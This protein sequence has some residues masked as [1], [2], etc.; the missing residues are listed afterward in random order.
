MNLTVTISNMRHHHVITLTRGNLLIKAGQKKHPA[1]YNSCCQIQERFLCYYWKQGQEVLYVG[2]VSKDYKGKKNNLWAR[3]GNYL[4]NHTKT[5]T[6]TKHANTNKNVFDA[7]N[8]L[9]ATYDLEFGVFRFDNC[10]VGAKHYPYADC[11][12]DPELSFLTCMIE[13]V[14]IGYYR[15]LGQCTWNR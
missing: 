6:I 7:A 5:N 3:V 13:D 2:S 12:N 10:E 15:S 14:L 8:R 9:L 1:F 4:Q 11:C